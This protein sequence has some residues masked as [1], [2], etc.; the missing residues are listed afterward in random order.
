MR[1]EMKMKLRTKLVIFMS[2]VLLTFVGFNLI[3]SS[4]VVD[5]LKVGKEAGYDIIANVKAEVETAA[6]Q[7]DSSKG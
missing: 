7:S 2:A 6:H 3:A 1:K 5:L 4:S